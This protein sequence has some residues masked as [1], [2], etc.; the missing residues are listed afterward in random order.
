MDMI[1]LNSTRSIEASDTSIGSDDISW[2]AAFVCFIP[3]I[4]FLI[5]EVQLVGLGAQ[6][7]LKTTIVIEN[8]Q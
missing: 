6:T 2:S 4:L 1:L 3:P 7:V 5:T 8:D